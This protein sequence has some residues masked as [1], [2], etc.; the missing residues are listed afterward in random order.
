MFFWHILWKRRTSINYCRHL[1]LLYTKETFPSTFE[2]FLGKTYAISKLTRICK[3]VKIHV[4]AAIT[5]WFDKVM[6]QMTFTL[7]ISQRN[8]GICCQVTQPI[9]WGQLYLLFKY[10]NVFFFKYTLQ[11]NC[12]VR[13]LLNRDNVRSLLWLS[14]ESDLLSLRC[15]FLI[16]E[17][18]DM[19]KCHSV[20]KKDWWKSLPCSFKSK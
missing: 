16:H 5:V 17:L 4:E 9:I 3:I 8:Y 10:V 2:L 7:I 19:Y 11:M 13:S 12:S 15:H 14:Q 20:I 6:Q 1:P 18:I